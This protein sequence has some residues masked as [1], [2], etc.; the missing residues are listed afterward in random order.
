MIYFIWKIKMHQTEKKLRNSGLHCCDVVGWRQIMWVPLRD[1]STWVLNKKP[2]PLTPH[3]NVIFDNQYICGGNYLKHL[4]RCIAC[5][6]PRSTIWPNLERLSNTIPII[7]TSVMSIRHRVMCP[8]CQTE[9]SLGNLT[10]RLNWTYQP[11][12]TCWLKLTISK[13]DVGDK[14]DMETQCCGFFESHLLRTSLV[15]LNV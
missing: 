2:S 5:A 3:K 8:F 4:F 12:W 9:Y 1:N 13:T 15:I 10:L 14:R 11:I 7:M 6:T